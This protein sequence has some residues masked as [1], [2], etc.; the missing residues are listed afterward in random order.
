MT[1]IRQVRKLS[2]GLALLCSMW[3]C[4]R[5][6][7]SYPPPLQIVFPSGPEPVVTPPAGDRLLLAMSDPDVNSHILGD[8]YADREGA[9][10]RFTGPHPRFRLHLQNS[11]NLGFYVRFFIHDESLAAHGQTSLSVDIN[12][13]RFGSRFSLPGDMEYRHLI[14]ENWI[15]APGPV[16]ISLDVDP[17]WRFSDTTVYGLHLHSIGFERRGK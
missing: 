16:D 9:E 2:L 6:P 12:G 5:P 3:S 7:E 4:A 14:P 13:H 17:P 10:W 1:N 15:T 8:V 11:V